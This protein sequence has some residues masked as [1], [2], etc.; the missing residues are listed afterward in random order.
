M[1]YKMNVLS[2]A[3]NLKKLYDIRESKIFDLLWI[4]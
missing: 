3:S 2:L 4:N 1:I